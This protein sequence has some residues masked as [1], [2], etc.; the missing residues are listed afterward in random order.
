MK[1]A[2][3]IL[4]VLLIIVAAL[5]GIDAAHAARTDALFL[6]GEDAYNINCAK[7]HGPSGS[8]SD[9]GPP[10]IHKIYEPSHHGDMS[11]HMAV[12][13]GVRAHHW[14]FGNMPPIEGV[15]KVQVNHIT[16]YIRALQKEAGIF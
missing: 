9:T 15:G 3:V 6:K 2:L 10:L 7:C 13:R 14:K 5:V 12:M 11:F 4:T 16:Y 1:D 8:G